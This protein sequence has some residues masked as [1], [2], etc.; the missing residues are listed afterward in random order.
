[1]AER[2]SFR[3]SRRELFKLAGFVAGNAVLFGLTGS[4]GGKFLADALGI[5]SHDTLSRLPFSEELLF[6]LEDQH[7]VT[8]QDTGQPINT[9]FANRPQYF[10]EGKPVIITAGGWGSF[11]RRKIDQ[12]STGWL[13]HITNYPVLRYDY[14]G[15]GDSADLN[16]R[17]KEGLHYGVL[18]ETVKPVLGAISKFYI[19]GRRGGRV[20]LNKALSVG[21]S[22]SAS[23]GALILVHAPDYGIEIKGGIEVEPVGVA[24]LPELY[25]KFTSEKRFSEE[26]FDL[27]DAF[28]ELLIFIRFGMDLGKNNNY[29][30]YIPA[31]SR[32]FVP[33][34][35]DEALRKNKKLVLSGGSGTDSE[36]CPLDPTQQMVSHLTT[37]Y[38]DRFSWDF[39]EG[40]SHDI[41]AKTSFSEYVEKKIQQ[42]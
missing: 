17:Q 40:L 41:F 11:N 21:V 9:I 7:R 33:S 16:S 5:T 37:T 29:F 6:E 28:R 24:N 31:L 27:E 8:S 26:D 35:F 4:A 2:H 3:P 14:L 1:M 13:A 15:I 42:I 38:S 30:R 20:K 34:A 25:K 12:I 39:F 19:P 22:M 32:E 10:I 23:T 36:V 18:D